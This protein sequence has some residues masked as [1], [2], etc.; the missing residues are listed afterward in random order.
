MHGYAQSGRRRC[1]S[2]IASNPLSTQ[3]DVAATLVAHC[4]IATFAIKGEDHKTYFQHV[5]SA[6]AHK[7]MITIDD[8]ADFVATILSEQKQFIPNLIGGTEET[9]TGV[10]RLRRL[11]STQKGVLNFPF[12]SVNDAQ[13][14]AFL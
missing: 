9:T 7:P 12:I 8:G 2:L 3:D 14:Q 11:W 1:R 6:L 10:V 5:Q 13:H 4:Q